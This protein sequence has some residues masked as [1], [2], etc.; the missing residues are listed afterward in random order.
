[1]NTDKWI[2]AWSSKIGS[3]HIIEGLPCQDSSK[4]QYIENTDFIIAAISDGAG[5]CV[6]SHIG[7]SFLVDRAVEKVATI[8]K[9]NNWME[10]ESFELTGD[11][12]REELFIIFKELKEELKT[13]AT[14]S[15]LDFKSLSATLIVAISNGKFIACAN[16]GDGRAAFR[17]EDSE[18]LPMVV[19][20]KGEEANQTLFITSDLWEENNQSEY[21]GTFFYKS[22]I[23][24]FTLLSDGC[25]RASFEIL[26][27]NEEEDKYF[28]PNKPY[29]PFFEPNYLNLLKL[30]RANFEQNQINDLW[31]IFLEKGN[32]KLIN[33]TDDKSMI[34]SVY[35][36]SRINEAEN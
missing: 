8:F 9:L 13:K 27:Y 12:W 26:K 25:E 2:S 10:N 21:F 28:D 20:T 14:E 22:P 24:A 11:K 36:I 4:V 1:M 29:K 32:Q 34:L 33:E 35:L 15:E 5:S 17:N 30:K 18:W 6:N 19:P 23:T 7:S 3:S 31:G 16:I